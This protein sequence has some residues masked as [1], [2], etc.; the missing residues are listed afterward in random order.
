MARYRISVVIES[1]SNYSD[2]EQLE[3]IRNEISMVIAD[4]SCFCEVGNVVIE[5]LN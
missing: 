3:D 4:Y 1:D 5:E 2:G